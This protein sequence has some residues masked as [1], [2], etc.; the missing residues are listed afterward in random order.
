MLTILQNYFAE[1]HKNMG[2]ENLK[3]K[4]EN[5]EKNGEEGISGIYLK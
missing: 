4:N 5:I 1:R 2:K 3:K